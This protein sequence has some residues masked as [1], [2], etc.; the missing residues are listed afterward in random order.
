MTTTYIKRPRLSVKKRQALVDYLFGEISQEEAARA[1]GVA[2]QN[3]HAIPSHILRA[4][5][6]EGRIDIQKLLD[7]IGV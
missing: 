1:I 2:R 5:V 7:D 3:F 6:M 4:I